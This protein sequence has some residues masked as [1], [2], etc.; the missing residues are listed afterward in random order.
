MQ[1]E[2]PSIGAC[3]EAI[4]S[5]SCKP[6]TF[7]VIVVDGGSTDRSREIVESSFQ[8]APTVECK[9]LLD[10]AGNTPSHLNVGLAEARGQIV[11]RVDARSFIPPG[12]LDRVVHVLQR[13]PAVV[14]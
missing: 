8:A 7:E 11:V 6:G 13:D 12:Y 10:P 5:Q 3:L 4:L 1:D 2:E 14:A 9:L